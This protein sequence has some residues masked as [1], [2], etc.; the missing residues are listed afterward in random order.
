VAA[1][2][3]EVVRYYKTKNQ[4]RGAT[5]N[6]GVDKA[7]G[8]YVVFID[9]DDVFYKNC[10]RVAYNFIVERSNPEVFHI[11]HEVRDSNN[12]LLESTVNYERFNDVL[13]KGNP[14]ACMNVFLR[15]DVARQH[16]FNEDRVMAGFEDWELWLRLA[17]NYNIP[18]VKELSGLMVDHSG[19]SS[20][21]H[22]IESKLVA[23]IELL[24]KNVL[25][26]PQVTGYYKS[27]LHLFICSCQTYVALHLAINGNKKQA[28]RHFVRGIRHHPGYLFNKRSAAIVKYLVLS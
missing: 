16:R 1:Y 6:Y 14:M 2:N 8:K 28:F 26:N 12:N 23:G 15:V 27:R 4:E 21:N 18:Q 19:R 25:S 11:A 7:R 17:A 3:P 24:M 5:R 10:F 20:N 9:S 13:I 22:N